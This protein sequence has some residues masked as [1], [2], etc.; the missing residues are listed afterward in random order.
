MDD[1]GVKLD[2]MLEFVEGMKAQ[3]MAIDTKLDSLTSA[4]SA[5]HADLQRLVGRPMLEMYKEWADSTTRAV[6]SKLQSTVYVPA[7]VCGPGPKKNFEVDE[8]QNP[9]VEV[10]KAFDDFMNSTKNVLLLS[11]AAGSGKSTTYELLQH[12]V[13]TT[14]TEKRKKEGVDVVLLP[15][16]LPQLNDPINGIFAEGCKFAYGGT[17][18]SGHADELR[19]LVQSPDSKIELVFFLDAYGALCAALIYSHSLTKLFLI[20]KAVPRNVRLIKS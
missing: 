9:T 13:L 16:S 4:V 15:I 12:R 7:E 17:L 6:G 20:C 19:E 10:I 11:G 3:V 5:M 2:V 18:R 1:L 14:Y 8:K